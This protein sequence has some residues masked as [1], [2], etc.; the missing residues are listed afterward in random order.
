MTTR[1][2]RAKAVLMAVLLLALGALSLQGR[3]AHA[4]L[5]DDQQRE[6]EVNL[7]FEDGDS[8][9]LPKPPGPGGTGGGNDGT[10]RA[11]PDDLSFNNPRVDAPVV[12]V[13]TTAAARPAWFGLLRV[14]LQQLFSYL[15]TL[16]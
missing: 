12:P 7:D 13:P 8:G 5:S 3:P 15:A 16:R 10:R 11:D 6:G 2:L 1:S 14:W 4:N 9:D